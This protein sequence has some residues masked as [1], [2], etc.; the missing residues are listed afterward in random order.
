MGLPL[1]RIDIFTREWI[2]YCLDLFT[3]KENTIIYVE[4]A[5]LTHKDKVPQQDLV[6]R[7]YNDSQYTS[8]AFRKPIS[9]LGLKQEH[10]YYSAPEQKRHIKSFH[11]TLNNEHIW[12]NNSELPGSR[13][14]NKRYILCL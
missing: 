10:I 7:T 6:I 14:G 4:D 11:K 1:K 9:V 13:I 2:G 8:K 12:S 3:V 5:L